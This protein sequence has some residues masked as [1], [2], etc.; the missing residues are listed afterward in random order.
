[1]AVEEKDTFPKLPSKAVDPVELAYDIMST[2][3]DAEGTFGALARGA[4]TDEKKA[5]A[6]KAGEVAAKMGESVAAA[7]LQP[8]KGATPAPGS[9]NPTSEEG[10]G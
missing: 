7:L 6:K 9:S 3:R 1:M 8:Q 2:G 10:A 5:T 4:S